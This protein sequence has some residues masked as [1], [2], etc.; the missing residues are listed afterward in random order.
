MYHYRK[1]SCLLFLLVVSLASFCQQLYP[2]TLL[3]RISGKGITHPSYLYG[4]MHLTDK[5]LFQFG[6]SV[7]RAIEKTDGLAIEVNPD[8]MG[9]YYINKALDEAEG[10]KLSEILNQKDYKKYSTAL[11]KKF[12]KKAS[13]VTTSDIVKEKNKW[14]ADYLEN[15]EMPTFVDAYLYNI[16]RRQGKWLGGVEDFSD[17]SGLMDELIDKSDIDFMLAGDSSLVKKSTNSMLSDMIDLYT[18]QNITGIESLAITSDEEKDLL[19]IKRNIKMARR[20]DSLMALRT[21]F[22]AV[23]AAHLAGDSGVIHLLQQRGFTVEPVFSSKKIDPKDYTFK[24]VHLPWTE[25]QDEKGLYKVSLPGNAGT[26]KLF[27]FVEMK[28]MFDIFNL[29]NYATMAII[30]PGNSLNK[31]SLLNALAQR[32]FRSKNGVHAKK[33][34][35]NG[36]EGNEYLQQLQGQNIRLQ[37]FIF[38]KVI[39]VAFVNALKK[40]TLTSPDANKF[41]SSFSINKSRPASSV[42]YTFIDSV[43]GISFMSPAE[44]SYNKKVSGDKDEAWHVSGFTGTD[45][46]SG[47]IVILFSKDVKP[48]HYIT[49]DTL[50][51]S[52]LA[53]QLKTQYSNLHKQDIN[54]QGYAGVRLSGRNIL[55]PNFYMNALSVVKNNRNIVVLVVS[56]SMHLKA[57]ETQKI[58]SSL[59]FIPP[60]AVNWALYTT[61]DSLLSARVP[62]AFRTIDNGAR[63]IL[64]SFDTTTASSYYIIADTLNKYTWYKHDTSFWKERIDYYSTGFSVEK[65]SDIQFNGTP[66]KE[67]L[68]K[69]D[70]VYKRM[71]LVLHE[72]K[73]YEAMVSGDKQFV[74][75]SDATAFLNSF[76][77]NAQAKYIN[78]INQPKANLVLNDLSDKDSAVRVEAYKNLSAALFEKSDLPLLHEALLKQYLSPFTSEQADAIN[79]RIATI[80]NQLSD[81]TTIAFIKE[82]YPS[83]SEKQSFKNV[84]LTVLAHVHTKES[85]ATLAQL[86]DQYG[87][88]AQSMNYSC[89]S[90]F[91]DSL[92]LTAGI[93]N[94]LQ[95]LAK[96]SAHTA[97]IAQLLV[98]LKD[99]GFL[100]QQQLV[101]AQNDYILT[102]RKILPLVKSSDDYNYGIFHIVKLLGRCNTIE[103]N[104]VLKSYLAVKNIYLKKAV[105]ME[106]VKNNQP[107]PSQVLTGL[108]AAK[109]IRFELYND[110]KELKKM[111]LFPKQFL[112]QAHFAESAMYQNASDDEE[113]EK[114]T[115]LSAQTTVYNGKQYVFYLYRV[116]YE[117]QNEGSGYLGI[118]GG[119]KPGNKNLEPEK[120]VT[121]IY[122][123]KNFDAS[124]INTLFKEYLNSLGSE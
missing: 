10:K 122:W 68:I 40:E 82:K 13:E 44:M 54:I 87:A 71:R 74:Y 19:L 67:L 118:A 23:G 62:G 110:L 63:R 60:P 51:H 53:Q 2:N 107:V 81:S 89:L 86:L 42:N 55:Q 9:A 11:S 43:M 111:A 77:I 39:Y 114:I 80:L 7:Y 32:M 91:K 95:K 76:T 37:A 117:T 4:T 31:D 112:T 29:S 46:A 18:S 21:M 103:A 50:I 26:V 113:P 57:P 116:V 85:Y 108:A 27:G 38:E 30:N 100:Q 48:G 99:S 65:E 121:G 17:Q 64:C 35:N 93:I 88:S 102:A 52:Q 22:V 3:W 115:F 109:D 79:L 69:K 47:S 97:V 58:F 36:I 61:A 1:L 96:D 101:A 120:D 66:G 5:R 90:A 104:T 75:N 56:D 94:S 106:L 6:D 28:F 73:I 16:A 59:R 12:K 83:L 20:I 34:V 119:F 15:G 124:K 123:E 72:N 105:V 24:E 49:S 33:V 41:F 8:E 84:A 98:T 78:F 14:F 70:I 25:V 92:A 45:M